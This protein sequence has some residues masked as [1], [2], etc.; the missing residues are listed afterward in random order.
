MVAWSEPWKN[1]DWSGRLTNRVI[2]CPHLR[3]QAMRTTSQP[4]GTPA[5]AAPAAGFSDLTSAPP[6]APRDRY[7]DGLSATLT[8]IKEASNSSP[9]MTVP[10]KIVPH[11]SA[12]SA[13]NQ[14][15][16][17]NDL[18]KKKK[19]KI[20]CRLRCYSHCHDTEQAKHGPRSRNSSSL[21][22][23]MH[24]GCQ[25]CKRRL[26]THSGISIPRSWS[27]SRGRQTIHGTYKP[28]PPRPIDVE[29]HPSREVFLQ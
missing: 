21:R 5:A 25:G 3:L 28:G 27:P 18:Q 22:E 24:G 16:I 13:A 1:P 14:S 19:K 26:E 9:Q 20:C 23:P 6:K 15:H 11:L 17:L 7:T 4:T 12:L 8:S 29:P 2:H 10:T